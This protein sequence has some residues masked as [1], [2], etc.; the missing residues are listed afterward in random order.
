MIIKRSINRVHGFI[1]S[2]KKLVDCWRL[3]DMRDYRAKGG[4]MVIEESEAEVVRRI[5]RMYLD[6]ESCYMIAKKLN[7]E[8]VPTYYGK[9]WNNRVISYMLRQEKYAGNCLM[10]KF[11]TESHVTHK[12][13]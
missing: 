11:F 3:P 7:A 1:V 6:G 5:F 2:V 4:E 13:V 9:E 10:Q 12:L 8:G